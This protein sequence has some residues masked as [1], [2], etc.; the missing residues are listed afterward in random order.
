MFKFGQVALVHERKTAECLLRL[1]KPT[2]QGIASLDRLRYLAPR[3]LFFF[4]NF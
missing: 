1:E 3:G 2:N 4:L